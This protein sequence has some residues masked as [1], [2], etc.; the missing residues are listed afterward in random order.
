VTTLLL[1]LLA[2]CGGS[3]GDS[4][5]VADVVRDYLRA[6]ADRDGERACALLT[7]EAQLRSFEFGR[8]HAAP[9][10]PGE[11]CASVFESYHP[12]TGEER[13]RRASVSGVEVR[14]NRAEA[15]AGGQRVKL[16]KVGGEWKLAVAGVADR[17]RDAAR[18]G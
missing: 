8:V 7:R 3:E 9:D 16:E 12:L 13:V 11:A 17:V 14:G 15:R 18:P 2:A 4:E 10:H 5:R 6:A 1:V